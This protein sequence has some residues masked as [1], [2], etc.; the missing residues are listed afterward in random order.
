MKL[1][2]VSSN[3]PS[4]G[5]C[6]FQY[7]KSSVAALLLSL[8]VEVIDFIFLR[9]DL[10]SPATSESAGGYSRLN[11]SGRFFLLVSF[12]LAAV[13]LSFRI[14]GFFSMAK[15]AAGTDGIFASAD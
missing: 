5:D 3:A 14:G 2:V 1:L 10:P 15:L 11:F 12:D 9:L 8:D 4:L 7:L 6:G 13:A